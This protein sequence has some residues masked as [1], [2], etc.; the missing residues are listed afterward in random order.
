MSEEDGTSDARGR[1][2]R[3]S[4]Y[5][6]DNKMRLSPNDKVI[7]VKNEGCVISVDLL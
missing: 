1:K 2:I 3:D 6:R 7:D 4:N 5:V